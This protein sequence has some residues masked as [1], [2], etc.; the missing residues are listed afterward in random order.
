MLEILARWYR[1]SKKRPASETV[2]ASDSVKRHA[3]LYGMTVAAY[4]TTPPLGL[5]KNPARSAVCTVLASGW[6]TLG[7]RPSNEE[8]APGAHAE[9]TTCVHARQAQCVRSDSAV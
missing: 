6:S 1:F 9:G 2:A 3:A 4:L 5:R 8:R 7:V